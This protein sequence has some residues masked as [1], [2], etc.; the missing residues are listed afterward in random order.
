MKKIIF[1]IL[2]TP[3]FVSSQTSD[4][5][6]I[7]I[8]GEVNLS[9]VTHF[10]IGS[11]YLSK[12]HQNPS[13]GWNFKINLLSY[14][15]LI[16]GAAYERSTLNVNDKVIGGNIEEST[17]NSFRTIL[18]YRINGNKKIYFNPQVKFGSFELIQKTGSK[19]YGNQNGLLYGLGIETNYKITNHFSIYSNLGYHFVT[20]QVSTTPEYEKYFNHANSIYFAIGISVH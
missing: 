1:L 4:K 15:N 17:T 2:L 12:G 18:S 13:L 6:S 7:E 8:K 19:N 11:N 20:L 3:H 9:F 14:K 5:S 10:Y 16:L